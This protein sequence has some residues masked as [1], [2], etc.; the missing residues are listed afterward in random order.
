MRRI[1]SFR[2]VPKD[3]SEPDCCA[4]VEAHWDEMGQL[5]GDTG[6]CEFQPEDVMGDGCLFLAVY[7]GDVIAGCGALRPMLR[8]EE[9]Y[10][11]ERSREAE[12]KRVYVKPEFRNQGAARLIMEAL[13]AAAADMGYTILSLE[14]GTLQPYAIQLYRRLGYT[15]GRP[16]GKYID[17]PR[18]VFLT[19]KLP[20]EIENNREA[21]WAHQ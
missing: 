6:P 18:S 21:P 20:S 17:D 4:L 1:C 2:I 5:Y 13:H 9:G 10:L 14:T 8:E 7:A 16:Y 12:V 19:L 3:P 11:P 15:D